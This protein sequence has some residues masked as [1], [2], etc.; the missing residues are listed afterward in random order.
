MCKL[1]EDMVN[2]RVERAKQEQLAKIISIMLN[3]EKSYTEIAEILHMSVS[4]VERIM[5]L[6]AQ[7]NPAFA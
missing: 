5:N 6:T 2:E 4:D 1:M 7:L 3:D